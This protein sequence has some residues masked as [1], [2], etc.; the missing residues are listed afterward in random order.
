MQRAR[1]DPAL[2]FFFS[3]AYQ[4]V[5]RAYVDDFTKCFQKYQ[6]LHNKGES[7]LSSYV[8]VLSDLRGVTEQ[9]SNA[10]KCVSAVILAGGE[11]R[12]DPRE[13]KQSLIAQLESA[14]VALQRT[15]SEISDTFDQMKS[16]RDECK[17]LLSGLSE[18]NAAFMQEVVYQGPSNCQCSA[19]DFI[20][21]M[22]SILS[23]AHED[24]TSKSVTVE[25]L[26]ESENS[27]VLTSYLT[28]WGLQPFID[29]EVLCEIEASVIRDDQMRAKLGIW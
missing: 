13:V 15:M 6:R 23:M 11:D 5:R 14:Y 18:N 29:K 9:M 8:S 19:V 2:R 7:E 16:L 20:A 27:F 25:S 1:E 4:R 17:S 21:F 22:S 24:L 10:K 12:L 3:T 28:A 26:N